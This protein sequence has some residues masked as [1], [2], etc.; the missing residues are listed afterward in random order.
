[1]NRYVKRARVS[2][3]EIPPQVNEPNVSEGSFYCIDLSKDQPDVTEVSLN[4]DHD[5]L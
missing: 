1:M 2:E 4:S 5:I 3:P